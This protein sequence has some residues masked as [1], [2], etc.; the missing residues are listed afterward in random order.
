[1]SRN[2]DI[3]ISN[4]NPTQT[5]QVCARNNAECRSWTFNNNPCQSANNATTVLP[6]QNG[7][8][9][10]S[11]LAGDNICLA[12]WTI[13]VTI[14]NPPPN[15]T[16]NLPIT[17]NSSGFEVQWSVGEIQLVK[18]LCQTSVPGNVIPQIVDFYYDNNTTSPILVC[19]NQ[20][21]SC[22]QTRGNNCGPNAILVAPGQLFHLQVGSLATSAICVNSWSNPNTLPSTAPPTFT[23][24]FGL[25][26]SLTTALITANQN[27]FFPTSYYTCTPSTT[28]L[29]TVVVNNCYDVTMVINQLLNGGFI[30]VPTVTPLNPR[31]S[32]TI[33]ISQGALIR[34]SDTNGIRVSNPYI[35]PTAPGP[36]TVFF[37][38]D[39]TNNPTSCGVMPIIPRVTINNC[40]TNFDGILEVLDIII[41]QWVTFTDPLTGQIVTIPRSGSRTVSIPANTNIRLN[42]GGNNVTQ[43]FTIPNQATVSV[44]FLPNGIPSTSQICP[45]QN[46]QSGGALLFSGH[47]GT[48]AGVVRN[49]GVTAGIVRNNGV[50][51][52]VVRTNGTTFIGSA[53]GPVAGPVL[54]SNVTINNCFDTNLTVQTSFDGTTWTNLNNISVNSKSNK[55]VAI[56]RGLMVRLANSSESTTSGSFTVPFAVTSKV[57]FQANGD[58]STTTCEEERLVGLFVSIIVIIIIIIVVIILL[59]MLAPRAKPESSAQMQVMHG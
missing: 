53:T 2:I 14:P 26:S 24:E 5:I 40:N 48:T 11:S 17:S 45:V 23:T 22:I 30:N 33:Q 13:P 47:N 56:V 29:T 18:T 12:L 55:I 41:G 51:A 50:T 21:T 7:R 8:I 57:F 3:F 32:V 42:Y 16:I 28:P 58:V 6:R 37:E 54:T 44:Y 25:D 52:G 43:S 19:I 49:N 4:V 15:S 36:V 59:F 46:P 10:I 9:T 39:G 35:V 31:G 34:L 38:A 1:M 20:P 27:F